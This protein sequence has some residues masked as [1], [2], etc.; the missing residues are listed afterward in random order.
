[1]LV[2]ERGFESPT[3]GPETECPEQ[4]SLVMSNIQWCFDRLIPTITPA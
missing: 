2:G 3:P 4:I 1:M